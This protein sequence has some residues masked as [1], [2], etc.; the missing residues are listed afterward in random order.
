MPLREKRALAEAFGNDKTSLLGVP[1]KDKMDGKK[2]LIYRNFHLTG[3]GRVL[4]LVFL[5]SLVLK[6]FIE[7]FRQNYKYFF[8]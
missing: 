3:D 6:Y 5:L 2:K 7:T 8:A 4:F 1:C